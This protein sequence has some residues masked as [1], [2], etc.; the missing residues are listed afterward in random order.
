M[1][2][3]TKEQYLNDTPDGEYKEFLSSLPEC[4]HC[5]SIVTYPSGICIG[6]LREYE[7]AE[8]VKG[9]T[10]EYVWGFNNPFKIVYEIVKEKDND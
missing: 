1:T 10:N 5:H 6:C 9:F 2:I 3:R 7:V 8:T 4:P